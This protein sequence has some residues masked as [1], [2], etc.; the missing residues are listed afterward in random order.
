MQVIYSLF[1]GL[2]GTPCLFTHLAENLGDVT[3]EY[4]E[5]PLDIP[6][7]YTSLEKW[8]IQKLDWEVPRIIIAESFSGPLALRLAKRF[9]SSVR[10]LVLAASFCASPKN[11]N[12]A[13]LPLRPLLMLKPPIRTLK[14]FFTS[15]D[16]SDQFILQL[17][18]TISKIPAKVLSER[19][20]SILSL[21]QSD[22]PSLQDIPM[23]ILQATDD[24]LI[25]WQ[26]QNQLQIQYQHA[27]TY[28]LDA[29]HLILQSN[30]EQC[31]AIIEEFITNNSLPHHV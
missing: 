9:P 26:T 27:S 19:I 1:P 24:N 22:C 13:L 16:V 29:P 4:I 14:Y 7:S 10:S 28:W 6:Q 12:L 18:D 2:H 5:Y 20:R 11:P 21:K 31:L 25:P 3:I 15:A 8:L 17:K 23:L 30:Q